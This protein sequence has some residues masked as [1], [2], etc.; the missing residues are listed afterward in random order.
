MILHIYVADKFIPPYVSF[1]N[2]NFPSDEHVHF[3]VNRKGRYTFDDNANLIIVDKLNLLERIKL[4]SLFGKADKVIIHG[5]F[6]DKIVRFLALNHKSLQK[7]YWVMWGGD[8][9]RFK[10][11]HKNLTSRFMHHI[12]RFVISRLGHFITY[13]PGDYELAQKWYG[14]KGE[15]HECFGY[16]SNVFNS[17]AH[18]PSE[19]VNDS[20]KGLKKYILLGNSASPSNR[21][22]DALK[23]LLPFKDRIRIFTPLTY[24][25]MKHAQKVIDEGTSLFGDAFVPLT[26]HLPLEKYYQFLASI[27]IVVFNHDRQQGMGTLIQMLALGKKVFIEFTTSPKPFFDSLGITVYDVKNIDLENPAQEIKEANGLRIK[28]FFSEQRL[29]VQ[30]Q[31]IFYK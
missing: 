7:C 22:C 20:N 23:Y 29:K 3:I 6:R 14:A 28:N 5:L 30:W 13:L 26:E 18:L 9:Y 15:Y 16:L 25:S 12:R 17:R 10:N 27:D 4:Q 1:V 8:L 11:K 24:G 21:H 31:D 2:M 19:S